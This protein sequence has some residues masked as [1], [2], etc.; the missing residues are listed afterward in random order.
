MAKL[1]RVRKCKIQIDRLSLDCPA[2]CGH[3][4]GH[5]SPW[6]GASLCSV[7]RVEEQLQTVRPMMGPFLLFLSS[8]FFIFLFAKNNCA[9]VHGFL[10]LKWKSG[11]YKWTSGWF[12]H[13]CRICLWLAVGHGS[14]CTATHRN[15]FPFWMCHFL[16]SCLFL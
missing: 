1:T 10:T 9:K 12:L 2:T 14:F 5:C 16:P 4:M 7:L 13:L 3:G 6:G 8:W 15:P 11:F